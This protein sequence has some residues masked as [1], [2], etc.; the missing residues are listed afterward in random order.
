MSLCVSIDL[1]EIQMA[2]GGFR[3]RGSFFIRIIPKATL[4]SQQYS[5]LIHG[6]V[7]WILKSLAHHGLILA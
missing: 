2:I 7:I 4:H 1:F 6:F 5:A 3:V